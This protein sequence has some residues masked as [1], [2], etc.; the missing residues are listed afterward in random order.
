MHNIIRNEYDNHP[1]TRVFQLNTP[2][3]Q[4]Y[5]E[6]SQLSLQDSCTSPLNAIEGNLAEK[7]S[8][9]SQGSTDEAGL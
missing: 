7:T 1:D 9:I 4:P 5:S 2:K 3:G 6:V 8:N